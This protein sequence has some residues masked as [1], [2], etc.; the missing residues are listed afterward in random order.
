MQARNFVAVLL[1]VT[2]CLSVLVPMIVSMFYVG[3]VPEGFREE[4]FKLIYAVLGAV[5]SWLAS[6]KETPKSQ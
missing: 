5:I 1:A 6:N 3:Q 4:M 2:V